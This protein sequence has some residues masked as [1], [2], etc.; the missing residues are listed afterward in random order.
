MVA[1]IILAGFIGLAAYWTLQ[2]PPA[3]LR[4]VSVPQL[5][6]ELRQIDQP[7]NAIAVG[8]MNTTTK[9]L[10]TSIEQN[11]LW[12]PGAPSLLE[13]YRKALSPKGW[14][15][16]M[17][18]QGGVGVAEVFCKG[19]LEAS[20]QETRIDTSGASSYSLSITSGTMPATECAQKEK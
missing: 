15:D 2:P 19:A 1:T 10:T 9:G 7:R 4:Y 13:S 14:V 3:N 5:V 11:Y 12:P 18:F 16:T 6:T 17:H 8:E 20:L